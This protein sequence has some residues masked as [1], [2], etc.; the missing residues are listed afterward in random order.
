MKLISLSFFR[1][2]NPKDVPAETG[3]NSREVPAETPRVVRAMPVP[4]S[5]VTSEDVP[6][7]TGQKSREIPA[8]FIKPKSLVNADQ[9]DNMDAQQVIEERYYF[10]NFSVINFLSCQIVV[11]AQLCQIL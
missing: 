9:M 4:S 6:A 1:S 2:V 7:K 3:Q 5:T 8:S 11:F 10:C